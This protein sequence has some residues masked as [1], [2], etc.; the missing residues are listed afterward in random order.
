M[1]TVKLAVSLMIMLTSLFNVSMIAAKVPLADTPDGMTCYFYAAAGQMAWQQNGGDWTDALGKAYGSEPFA[2]QKIL[3]ATGLQRIRWDITALARQWIAGAE[4]VGGLLLRT[5]PGSKSGIVN[6]Y[7]RESKEYINHPILVIEWDDNTQ[8]YLKP[9]VD[10]HFSCPTY[11]SGG[12][13]SIFKVG[14]NHHSIVVFPLEQRTK[15]MLRQAA[16]I[17]TTD[18]QYAPESLVGIFRPRLPWAEPVERRQ[19]IAADFQFDQG[20]KNHP[21]V[22]F[23]DQF[24]SATSLLTGSSDD[25]KAYV[26]N[27]LT[28]RNRFEPL[29]GQ[30]LKVTIAQGKHQGLN[31]HYRFAQYAGGEPEE[32]YFRYYLRLSDNW[33]PT[34]TG[35]KLPG[36][37]GTYGRAGWGGRKSDGFNGWSARGGFFTK[38]EDGSP[39]SEL[40][41]VGSYAYHAGMKDHYGD[42]WGWN[43]GPTGM[44]RK[45]HWYSVEQYVKLNQPGQA[46]GVLRA[47]IDG[48]LVFEKQNLRFRDVQDLKIES[49][50]M[51]VYHGGTQPAPR[52]MT[53]YIDNVV[54]ARKYIGP[55]SGESR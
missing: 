24:E 48:Q 51:N 10:I 26:Q 36:L 33:N 12:A 49:V 20:I 38:S 47:W 34:V 28:D 4:P 7:S 39:L 52:D 44:L 19:G 53:L 8:T 27:I 55:F 43:L 29:N 9:S 45:N 23:A 40:Y 15:S 30:A 35:G 22:I 31:G 3:R 2:V 13:D 1:K 25:K 16:L 18:K 41:G 17:L 14:G 50:W 6:F 21:D 32:V 54:A 46:D 42:S 5:L 37:S 11:K